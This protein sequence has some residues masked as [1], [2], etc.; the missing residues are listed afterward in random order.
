M[1][2]PTQTPGSS[3]LRLST[4]HVRRMPGIPDGFELPGLSEGVTV[5]FGPN[6]SGKSS[7]AR[8]IEAALW[9]G[10]AAQR[11]VAVLAEFAMD[12]SLFRVEVDAGHVA[13]Q[14]DGAE[15]RPPE[16]PAP[17]L[18]HRY[19]LSLHELM[20][21]EDSDFAREIARQSAGGYDLGAAAEALEFRGQPSAAKNAS[22]AVGQ[23]LEEVRAAQLAQRDLEERARELD[24]L[25]RKR[26]AARAARERQQLLVLA[27]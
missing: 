22:A 14:R 23:A 10:H 21:C 2:T 20:K 9:P 8:A 4:L 24:D 1:S 27:V 26:D 5:V 11:D 19:R 16:L 6:A 18:R 12:G 3:A 7:T 13:V 25:R 17:E 15:A